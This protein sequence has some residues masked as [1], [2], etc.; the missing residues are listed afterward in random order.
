[1]CKD[2]MVDDLLLRP[3]SATG[4]VCV[5]QPPCS[6]PTTEDSRTCG[7]SSAHL[8]RV[9]HRAVLQG[10]LQLLRARR[11]RLHHLGNPSSDRTINSHYRVRDQIRYLFTDVL[12]RSTVL[13]TLQYTKK[14]IHVLH[15]VTAFSFFRSRLSIVRGPFYTFLSNFPSGFLN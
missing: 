3:A 9:C 10:L 2:N 14:T 4:S 6:E 13:N 15:Y 12:V 7:R 11:H 1:M 8:R 5:C